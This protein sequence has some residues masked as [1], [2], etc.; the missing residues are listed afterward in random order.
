[1][2]KFLRESLRNPSIWIPIIVAFYVGVLGLCLTGALQR[3][4]TQIKR[5]REEKK[6]IFSML[7]EDEDEDDKAS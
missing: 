5:V 3:Q 4:A 6:S 1:L 7:D 2:E